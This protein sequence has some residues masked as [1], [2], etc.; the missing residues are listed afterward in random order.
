MLF[1]VE[2]NR[3]NPGGVPTLDSGRAFIEQVIFPTLARAEELAQEKR[4]LAGGAVAGQV[5][6]RFI[7]DAQSL[8]EVDRVVTTLPIWT[9]AETRITPLIAFRERREHVAAMLERIAGQAAH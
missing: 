6:L 4:L 2:L 7:V 8:E 3:V 1:L 5:A 9:V